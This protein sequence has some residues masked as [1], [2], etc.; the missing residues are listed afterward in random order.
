MWEK[1]GIAGLFAVFI[2]HIVHLYREESRFEAKRQYVNEVSQQLLCDGTGFVIPIDTPEAFPSE[3]YPPG[4]THYIGDDYVSFRYGQ[5]F[6]RVH[7][8][9]TQ[10]IRSVEDTVAFLR[11]GI[12]VTLRDRDEESRVPQRG[13]KENSFYTDLSL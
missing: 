4:V 7:F 12:E 8:Y 2:A 1:I 13:Q 11:K 9:K 10:P 5:F 3:S 6:I